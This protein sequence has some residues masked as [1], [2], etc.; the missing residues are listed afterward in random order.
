MDER[1]K[2][3]MQYVNMRI[4]PKMSATLLKGTRNMATAKRYEVG[5]QLMSPA[6]IWNSPPIAGS[7]ILSDEPI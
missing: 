3:Y 2:I 6:P 1:V 4:L 7:V 5:T